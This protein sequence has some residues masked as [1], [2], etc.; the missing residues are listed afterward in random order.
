M[1]CPFCR[2]PDMGRRL[3]AP[4][5]GDIIRRRRECD[6]RRRFTTYERVEE[7]LPLVVKKDGRREPFDR[8]KIVAG[9]HE[10]LRE[11]ARRRPSSSRQIVI[12]IERAVQESRREGDRLARDRRGGHARAARARR[13][14]LRALRLGVPLVP[15]RAEFMHELEELIA[16]AGDAAT[17]R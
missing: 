17:A 3:A 6:V 10:G 1:R 16:A 13:G 7:M 4:Q 11:A 8:Q 9:L 15:R 2:A 14:G 12:D 5:E